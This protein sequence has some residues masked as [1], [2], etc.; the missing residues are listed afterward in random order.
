MIRQS[1]MCHP[2][3]AVY[4]A[5]WSDDTH[6]IPKLEIQIEAQTRCVNWE[7]VDDWAR[8]RALRPGWEKQAI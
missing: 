8:E 4:T 7:S 6:T 1:L 2:N 3:L 5:E